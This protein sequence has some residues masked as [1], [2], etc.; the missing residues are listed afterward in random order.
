MLKSIVYGGLFLLIKI[1]WNYYNLF[2]S[3]RLLWFRSW[4]RCNAYFSN[5]NFNSRFYSNGFRWLSFFKIRCKIFIWGRTLIKI[6]QRTEPLSRRNSP[7]QRGLQRYEKKTSPGLKTHTGYHR[8]LILISSPQL[9]RLWY[10][11]TF[12]LLLEVTDW[13]RNHITPWWWN[14]TSNK[15]V[16]FIW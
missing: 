5:I 8:L 9:M 12:Q 16:S 3:Y 14:K 11:L 4:H 15:N 13:N 6:S 7:T 10:V 1:W 2:C